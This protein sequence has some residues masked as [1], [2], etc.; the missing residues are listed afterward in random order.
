M[1]PAV[2]VFVQSSANLCVSCSLFVL[3]FASCACIESMVRLSM[4]NAAMSGILSSVWLFPRTTKYTQ[5]FFEFL[6]LI[7]TTHVPS[8]VMYVLLYVFSF[9]LS[10]IE[11][12]SCS[13]GIFLNSFLNICNGIIF[14]YIL[15][16]LPLACPW[17]FGPV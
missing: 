11:P 3:Q 8:C 6:N 10:F 14:V 17:V 4:F 13:T 9:M 2:F 5:C 7:V 15:L 16:F 12:L 1:I